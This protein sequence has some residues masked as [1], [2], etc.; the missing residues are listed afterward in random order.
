MEFTRGRFLVIDLHPFAVSSNFF[1]SNSSKRVGR[2]R[3]AKMDR[4]ISLNFA[5][6]KRF[7]KLTPGMI[8]FSTAGL[9]VEPPTPPLQN[10]NQQ[11]IDVCIFVPKKTQ[12][13]WLGG[14]AFPLHSVENGHSYLD[15]FESLSGLSSILQK[16]KDFVAIQKAGDRSQTMKS[17][18]KS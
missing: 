8:N 18:N 2:R 7:E 13:W 16:S 4:A 14:R 5:E 6:Q 12:P 15:G 17:Y 1:A 3:T 11:K 10:F 9:A